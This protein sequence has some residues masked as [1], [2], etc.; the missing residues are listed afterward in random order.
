MDEARSQNARPS[1]EDRGYP[2]FQAA[3]AGGVGE[4]DGR[5][6]GCRACPR[7]VAWRE[8]VAATKRAAFRDWDYWGRPVPG[9]GPHDAPL[10]V[11]G[12]APAAHGANRTGRM[13]TGDASGDF[14]FAALHAVG[15]ASRPTATTADDGLEL[16]GVRVTSPVH[17][18]PP[19][20]RPTP[21]ERDTCRPWLA[22]ELTLLG[23]RVI[24][25]LGA[26]GWQTLLPVL[27]D[28]GWQLPRP[29]P[30]FAHG[31]VVTLRR[32]EERG[33]AAIGE[34]HVI[35]CYH[36]SQRNTFTGRLTSPML[37]DLLHQ[38]AELAGLSG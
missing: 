32:G 4:L 26:F 6:V 13:F 15:L 10:V 23:P 36:P 12:L 18:A 21:A 17:C 14:L 31:T 16:Y 8:E 24:V 38:A 22:A 1:A 28:A 35:G 9:F 5:I 20:N 37:V 33:R 11:V 25:V 2:V 30:P 7:L 29:R 19:G 3:R 27:A 34:L